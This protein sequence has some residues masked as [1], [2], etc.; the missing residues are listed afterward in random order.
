M[1]AT[2]CHTGHSLSAF[3]QLCCLQL[4][5]LQAH[6]DDLYKGAFSHNAASSDDADV[7]G[8]KEEVTGFTE[9]AFGRLGRTQPQVADRE[10]IFFALVLVILAVSVLRVVIIPLCLFT[11]KRCHQT[12]S[13]K[14]V[15]TLSQYS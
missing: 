15:V 5:K 1:T 11:I 14:A 3:D 12:L 13:P 7:N 4:H 2:A 6:I 10:N 8:T 9:E